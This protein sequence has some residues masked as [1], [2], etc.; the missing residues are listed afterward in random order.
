[1]RL[2]MEGLTA[3]AGSKPVYHSG[4]GHSAPAGTL[5]I[6]VGLMHLCSVHTEPHMQVK[7]RCS[8]GVSTD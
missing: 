1:M 5:A 3:A 4:T 6:V 7:V 2:N 8:S